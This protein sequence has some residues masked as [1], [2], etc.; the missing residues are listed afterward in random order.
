MK[1]NNLPL[2]RKRM[3]I[4]GV[5][6]A[7]AAG[8]AQAQFTGIGTTAPDAT[9]DVVTADTA[10]Q[11][12][13]QIE[14]IRNLPNTAAAK[15]AYGE[16]LV[17]DSGTGLFR[18]ESIAD[19]LDDNGEWEYDAATQT[20]APRRA[21][22]A[23]GIAIDGAA[24]TV[25]IGF[26]TTVNNTFTVGAFA[27]Q[28]GGTLAVTGNTD[29]TGTLDI[30]TV[31]QV[32]EADLIGTD[33]VLIQQA[34]TDLVEYVTVDDLISN[35]SYWQFDGTTL[36][37]ADA[38][39]AGDLTIVDGAVDVNATLDVVG[40]TTVT[41]TF[42]VTGNSTITG[43]FDVT[44]NTA[45]DGTLDVTTVAQ[46]TAADLIGTDEV[47]IQQAGTDLVEYVTVD[48]LISNASYWQFDGTTLEPADANLAGDF[49][50]TDGAVDVVATLD[51]TGATTV[52]GTFDVTGNTLVDGT[53]GVT[54]ANVPNVDEATLAA[55][56]RVIIQTGLN[57]D[58]S[59]VTVEDLISNASY[60]QFD[61]TTNT[62]QPADADIQ[63]EFVITENNVDVVAALSVTGNTDV[64]GTFDVT[65]ASTLDG[66]LDVTGNTGLDGT[67][68]IGTV[69]QVAA[70]DI[71]GTDE[72]LLQQ[73]GTDLV[74]YV[75]V[76][77]LLS[78]S[79][80]WVYEDNGTTGVVDAADRVYV[81]RLD[82]S[83]DDVFVDGIGNMVLAA[84]N[85]YQFG[86]ATNQI[87]ADGITSSTGY[88]LNT[89]AT[90]DVSFTEAGAGN[91]WLY[92]AAAD[93]GDD[94]GRVG[95]GTNAPLA[96]LHVQ[97]NIIASHTA[98][99]SD[100]RFKR[101]IEEF[102]GALEA[103]NA[104]RGVSY[105]F[106]ADEFPDE[107]FDDAEHLGFIAQELREILPQT[108]FEREDG[109]LTVDYSALT[110]VLAE[111]IQELSA[112]VASLEA[113]NAGLKAG[114][115]VGAAD[116]ISKLEARIADLDARL[117]EVAGRK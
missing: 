69:A 97:G 18:R 54:Q 85:A 106:R 71:I 63:D 41:G 100:A 64:T 43:T 93:A 14:T 72:I 92:F 35:A 11:E 57:D 25:G 83:G 110:P 107:R 31:A 113:E 114:P 9:L 23:G 44:G 115:A 16:V 66:T 49:E 34:G 19:L 22:V 39:L 29:L 88:F 17:Y 62:L 73:A 12:P 76:D 60:W 96:S 56:D 4:L 51:V 2:L 61:A 109:F 74:E 38:A 46:V 108:V 24:S 65:G 32:L 68:E 52:I 94:N 37:P 117:E 67:L 40:N 5:S 45:L 98:Q 87:E 59:H 3:A 27:T 8:T 30:G 105:T 90:Q 13:L 1:L 10:T 101:D 42:D 33:E 82:G 80:E 77:D 103:I 36:Q 50:I 111:A 84:D 15:A 102:T 89:A 7:V 112:K 116:V 95:I 53:F 91:P 78:S 28:L 104:V 48:D 55:T 21:D 47:L 6:A 75:T 20:L 26:A 70:G 99:T 58:I 86:D 79:G 81:R